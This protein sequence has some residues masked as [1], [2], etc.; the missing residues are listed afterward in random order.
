MT[1]VI[2]MLSTK[3][4]LLFLPASCLKSK[5]REQP[6][7]KIYHISTGPD[8]LLWLEYQDMIHISFYI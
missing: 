6:N 5:T 1:H 3:E 7:L 8:L 2:Q 4:S